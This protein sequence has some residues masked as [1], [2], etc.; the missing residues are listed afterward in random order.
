M[1]HVSSSANRASIEAHGLD[2]TRMDAVP[3]IAGSTAPEVDG[4]FLCRGGD[5]GFFVRLNNTGTAVDVWSVD[6]V[7]ESLLVDGPSGWPYLPEP[8]AP[9]RLRLVRRDVAP[10]DPSRDRSA[11]ASSGAYR[12]RLTITFDDGRVLTGDEATEFLR[13]RKT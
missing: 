5:V 3:G 1:F 6:D 13:Q 11:D 8:I 10:R 4:V 12:S 2:W 9:T 7:D